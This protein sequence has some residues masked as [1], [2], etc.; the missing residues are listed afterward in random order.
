MKSAALGMPW[1][2]APGEPIHGRARCEWGAVSAELT[3]PRAL[4]TSQ[5]LTGARP[6]WTAACPALGSLRGR[7]AGREAGREGPNG[8]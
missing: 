5:L 4:V 8:H 1:G 3:A 6:V 7:E 2:P